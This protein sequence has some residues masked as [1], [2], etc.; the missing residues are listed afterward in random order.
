MKHF[1]KILLLTDF[2]EVSKNA[3][4]YALLIAKKTNAEIEV[5]HI[6]TTTIDWVNISMEQEKLYPE[7]ITVIITAKNKM[8]E[9]L[10]VFKKNGIDAKESIVFNVGVEN[11]P[12]YI[13]QKSIDLV[14]LGSH[15]ASGIKE[16]T[17]GS[18]AE[19]V[20]RHSKFPVL[21]VKNKPVKSQL[22]T[23][24]FAS[25]FNENQLDSFQKIHNFS[26][27]LNTELYL[28]YINTPY[29]FKETH[30]I[31]RML[32]SFYENCKEK[33][34]KKHI[35]NAFNEE[36]GV[37]EFIKENPIDIFAIAT[38]GRSSFVQLFSPSLTENIINHLD[39]PV[40]SIHTAE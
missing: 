23:I 18:N 10:A 29:N 1:N 36:R 13:A 2:S 11:I 26:K 3:M 28:L 25:N 8:S 7:T 5:M 16:F 35:Y 39:I 40:L 6:I 30:S 22:S 20:V 24:A 37:K 17:L 9:M 33:T 4:E 27:L 19:K 12:Q 14:I 21:V 15:G 34:C 31:D 38:Q 32:H